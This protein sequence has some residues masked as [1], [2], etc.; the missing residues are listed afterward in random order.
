M[1]T[2]ATAS[3]KST[4]EA[5]GHKGD[6]VWHAYAA[7]IISVDGQS[8][9]YGKPEDASHARFTQ[10]IAVT[11]DFGAPKP[12]GTQMGMGSVVSKSAL[13]K[14]KSSMRITT[15]LSLY[16]KA[17]QLQHTMA[18]NEYNA[19]VGKMQ[20][21]ESDSDAQDRDNQGS[22]SLPRSPQSSAVF[23]QMLKYNPLHARVLETLWT[24]ETASLGECVKPL[25]ALASPKPYRPWY[26]DPVL[27]P[28]E[29]GRCPYCFRKLYDKRLFNSHRH[30][31]RHVLECHQIIHS[32]TFCVQCAMF[33]DNRLIEG[34][35]C[36]DLDLEDNG[37][38]GVILWRSLV[39]SEGRCPYGAGLACEDRLFTD[40]QSLKSHINGVH[41]KKE[42]EG[43][44]KCP[45][46]DCSVTAESKDHLRAHL[47]ERHYVRMWRVGVTILEDVESQE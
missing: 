41:I 47:Q 19:S 5:L 36:L 29:N 11:R 4:K 14:A 34:H 18:R 45:A 33:V 28:K 9:A 40:P 10:S 20:A 7:P 37:I 22:V 21:S 32:V 43:Y 42:A 6:R 3:S 2:P 17:R 44:Q 27:S 30:R 24:A 38:Y 46:T 1:Y 31:A 23:K 12:S 16:R 25:V 13:E 35:M 15:D 26:P 39:I 8:I